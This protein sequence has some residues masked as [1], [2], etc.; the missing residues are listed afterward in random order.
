[1]HKPLVN[2]HKQCKLA[3][4]KQ[5][6]PEKKMLK[7]SLYVVIALISFALVAP[8]H[9]QE[10]ERGSRDKRNDRQFVEKNQFDQHDKFQNRHEKRQEYHRRA[11]FREDRRYFREGHRHHHNMRRHDHHDHH[12]YFD[13][14]HLMHHLVVVLG[15][16]R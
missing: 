14:L 8:V 2:G 12:A 16:D 15:D 13:E 11:E 5:T 9:A 10:Y 3:I 1:M 4:K 7:K 6:N